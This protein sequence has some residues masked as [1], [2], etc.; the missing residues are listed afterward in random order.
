MSYL[1]QK[2][3]PASVILD[4]VLSVLTDPA[5]LNRSSYLRS[6]GAAT[7]SESALFIRVGAANRANPVGQVSHIAEGVTRIYQPDAAGLCCKESF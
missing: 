7:S 4:Y 1:A 2:L 3:P 5:T 6:P